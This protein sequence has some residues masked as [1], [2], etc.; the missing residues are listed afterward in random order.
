LWIAKLYEHP[1]RQPFPKLSQQDLANM[2]GTT[3]QRV[4]FFLR[5]FQESG[6]VDYGDVLRVHGSIVE[7]VGKD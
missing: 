6:F 7:V 4:N 2:I 5:R 1:E 3:R